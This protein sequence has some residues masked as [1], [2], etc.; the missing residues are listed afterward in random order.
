MTAPPGS[1]WFCHQ[2]RHNPV[3]G[4]GEILCLSCAGS[5][6]PE[7]D[8]RAEYIEKGKELLARSET[9]ANHGQINSAIARALQGILA[10]HIAVAE[11]PDIGMDFGGFSLPEPPEPERGPKPWG[12]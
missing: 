12:Q 2:C 6:E 1:E 7:P 11:A 5:T 10:M 4:P 9:F 3:K 8:V